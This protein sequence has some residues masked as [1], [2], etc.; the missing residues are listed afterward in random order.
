[1][2]FNFQ[3]E[4]KAFSFS[5]DSVSIAYRSFSEMKERQKFSVK[6]TMIL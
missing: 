2:S 1:M 5:V 3:Q 4:K 6:T